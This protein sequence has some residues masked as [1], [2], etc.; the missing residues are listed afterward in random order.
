MP[1]GDTETINEW[2]SEK[3]SKESLTPPTTPANG[4]APKQMES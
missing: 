4:L 1:T 3:V 2:K